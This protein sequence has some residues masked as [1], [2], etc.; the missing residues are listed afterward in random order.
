MSQKFIRYPGFQEAV[1]ATSLDGCLEDLDRVGF[2]VIPGVGKQPQF[3]H[4][5][6]PGL[7]GASRQ[8]EPAA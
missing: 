3:W 2:F 4:C 7:A 8:S 6:V 1:L 5:D